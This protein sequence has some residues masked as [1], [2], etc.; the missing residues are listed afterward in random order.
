MDINQ[1]KN[2]MFLFK[3]K[4]VININIKTSGGEEYCGEGNVGEAIWTCDNNTL[5]F[6]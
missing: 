1:K 4:L 3:Y 6:R 5:T 2:S